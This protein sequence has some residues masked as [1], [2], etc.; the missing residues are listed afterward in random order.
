MTPFILCDLTSKD[1][2]SFI[3]ARFAEDPGFQRLVKREHK[4]AGQLEDNITAKADRVFLW[5]S[6]VVKSLSTGMGND[7]RVL[8]M[9]RRLDQ[10]PPELED[11]YTTMLNSLQGFYFNRAAEY[12]RLMEAWETSPPAVLIYL[13]DEMETPRD[14]KDGQD[15]GYVT[16]SS[17]ARSSVE[18]LGSIQYTHKTV[19]DYI[20]RPEVQKKIRD[21][22]KDLDCQIK[23]CSAYLAAFKIV[24]VEDGHDTSH[25]ATQLD[26]ESER[27]EALRAFASSCL[28]AAS[29][30][31]PENKR[32]M[33]E[34]LD[35]LCDASIQLMGNGESERAELYLVEYVKEK[36]TYGCLEPCVP[37]DST[38]KFRTTMKSQLKIAFHRRSES[39]NPPVKYPHLYWPLLMDAL[40]AA[41][42][43]AI[44]VEL[45]SFCLESGADPNFQVTSNGFTVW[46]AWFIYLAVLSP[47][48]NT[49]GHEEYI[50]RLRPYWPV[51]E[52]LIRHGADTSLRSLRRSTGNFPV[53]EGRYLHGVLSVPER[54][55]DAA[56]QDEAR[57]TGTEIILQ[58]CGFE[59]LQ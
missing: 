16:S 23:I 47:G 38:K 18:R 28:K 59:I 17:I 1:I 49:V 32:T 29:D 19:R 20:R 51:T 33:I 41:P 44:K 42:I 53:N 26:E 40:F 15:Q 45:V 14:V 11:L 10:L 21:A 4:Y 8:D 7:D 36:T 58:D 30:V 27:L 6:L 13:I 43:D 22:T 24:L 55:D 9:Q 3:H 52:K 57:L 37:E 12:F 56:T 34:L 31:K 54:F 48:R 50:A 5:V 25:N 2:K 35:A 46:S 39:A